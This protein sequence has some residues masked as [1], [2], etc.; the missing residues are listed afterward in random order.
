MQDCWDSGDRRWTISS[1]VSCLESSIAPMVKM[2]E[3]DERTEL[4]S[5][6]FTALVPHSGYTSAFEPEPEGVRPNRREFFFRKLNQ[7]FRI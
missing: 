3:S 1:I 7:L 6:V 5:Q 4:Q 2:V